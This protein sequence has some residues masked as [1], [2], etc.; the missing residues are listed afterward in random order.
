MM[1]NTA[2]KQLQM[3]PKDA[4]ANDNGRGVF[5]CTGRHLPPPAPTPVALAASPLYITF[6]GESGAPRL[7]LHS[8]NAALSAFMSL[9]RSSVHAGMAKR[10]SSKPTPVR[11]K[12]KTTHLENTPEQLIEVAKSI[13]RAEQVKLQIGSAGR[14]E[15]PLLL[16]AY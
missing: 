11:K 15:L 1:D 2:S 8:C 6:R 12:L 5:R 13:V 16:L 10:T 7:L 4:R 9:A 3:S 14:P